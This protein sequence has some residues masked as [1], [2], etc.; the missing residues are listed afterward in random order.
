MK[1]YLLAVLITVLEVSEYINQIGSY[2]Q[3]LF[4]L[5]VQSCTHWLRPRNLLPPPPA[6]GFIY[7]D[8]IGQP[9]KTTSLSDPLILILSFNASAIKQHQCMYGISL[10]CLNFRKPIYLKW[11]RTGIRMDPHSLETQDSDPDPDV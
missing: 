11:I 4:G 8:A 3:S 6:F 1:R 9:R 5:H 2:L 10:L 7:E